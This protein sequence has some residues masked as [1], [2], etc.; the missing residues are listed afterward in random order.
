MGTRIMNFIL[1]NAV[2]FCIPISILELC[3]LMELNYLEMLLDLGP[4]PGLRVSSCLTLGNEFSMQA[5]IPAKQE[6][7][8]NQAESGRVKEPRRTAL[9]HGSQSW[10]L[11]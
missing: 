1:L 2:Y 5:Y 3:S 9:P 8:F 4:L 10:G 11:W 7:L 6:T